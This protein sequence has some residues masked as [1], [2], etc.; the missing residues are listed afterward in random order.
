[1]SNKP[2]TAFTLV[3]LL[4]VISIIG[5]LAAL[6]LPALG[7]ARE[8]ARRIQC[9]TNERELGK[10]IIGYETG[11]NG[12]YPAS[13]TD[14][15]GDPSKPWPWAP[16][17]FERIDKGDLFRQLLSSTPA[18]ANLAAYNQTPIQSLICPSDISAVGG[19]AGIS[20]APNMGT[21]DGAAAPFDYKFNGVFHTRWSGMVTPNPPGYQ[22][23]IKVSSS[24]MADGATNTILLA[25]NVNATTWTDTS[26][27]KQGIVWQKAPTLGTNF[28]GF[29]RELE[30][31][32]VNDY[33]HA[34]PAS[35][36]PNGFNVLFADGSVRFLN[37][38]ISYRVYALLMTPDGNKVAAN[39]ASVSWQ[40]TAVSEADLNP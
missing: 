31:T 23:G 21:P 9:T 40:S 15:P 4:V 25:E 5:V 29:N 3:E 6:T 30:A 36:H 13:F 38:E 24:D 26:E 18:S 20:Y 16:R 12:M 35:R 37:E 33:K 1:M 19:S 27:W 2:R 7:A 39:D 10:A 14:M 34:R 17:I 28:A 22:Q 11:K 32:A 8:A